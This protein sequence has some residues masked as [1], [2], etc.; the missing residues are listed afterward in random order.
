[1]NGITIITTQNVAINFK[2]ASLGERLLA[3]AIDMAIK[4]VYIIALFY[5]VF[6]LLGLGSFVNAF[7]SWEQSSIMFLL[8]SPTVFYTLIFESWTNGQTPGKMLLKIR[9]VKLE[10]Y[11]AR[12]S[13]Y[14]SRWVCRLI[15]IDFSLGLPAM[16]SIIFSDK[17]QRLGDIVADTT[18]VSLKSYIQLRHRFLDEISNEY[19]V[20]FPTVVRL[21][22]NDMNIIKKAYSNAIMQNDM[23]MLNKLVLKIEEVT[24]IKKQD[25]TVHQFIQTIINDFNHLT[26]K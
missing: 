4:I 9:V 19:I 8:F 3:F 20:T 13:D 21:S 26:S 1:M 14:F 12:F 5:F 18:V 11:Q 16:V 2:A 22:D 17:S 6:D 15:D 10:G 7:D 23:Q 24:E 25:V